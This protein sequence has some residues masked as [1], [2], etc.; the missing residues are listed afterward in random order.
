MKFLPL[1]PCH[2]LPGTTFIEKLYFSQYK[3][4]FLQHDKENMK[5]M[6][7]RKICFVNDSW[8]LYLQSLVVKENER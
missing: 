1:G 6:S 4:F 2:F 7:K 3:R 8:R 5:V